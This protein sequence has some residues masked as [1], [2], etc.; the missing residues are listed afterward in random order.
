MLT[1][2][3]TLPE[4]EKLLANRFAIF[5][6][7]ATFGAV[8]L[9]LKSR[10]LQ[11]AS[12]KTCATLFNYLSDLH[13]YVDEALEIEQTLR[14]RMMAMTSAQFERVLHPIFEE[15]ELTLIL[16]G[17]GLG[18]LAGLIQ[19]LVSTGS[20]ILPRFSFGDQTKLISTLG[21]IIGLYAVSLALKPRKSLVLF[22][23]RLIDRTRSLK[24]NTKRLG[25]YLRG[26]KPSSI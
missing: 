13:G 2:A 10:K 17:G 11:A 16:A 4:W 22:M 1:D 15:D 21:S 19:Q 23:K 24:K 7:D 18:F 12:A 14:A 26:Q 3:T 5:T 6:K 20:I 8:D 25:R 9:Q